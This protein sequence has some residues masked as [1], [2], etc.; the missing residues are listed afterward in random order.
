MSRRSPDRDRDRDKDRG[1][2]R[3]REYSASSSYKS[4]PRRDYEPGEVS[5]RRDEGRREREREWEVERDPRV[6]PSVGSSRR[7]RSPPSRNAERDREEVTQALDGFSRYVLS[8]SS[9]DND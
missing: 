8:S 6:P 5:S 1:R 7:A 9:C 4:R 2:E 3:D